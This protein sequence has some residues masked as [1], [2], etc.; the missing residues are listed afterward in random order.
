[1]ELRGA[2]GVAGGDGDGECLLDRL[3]LARDAASERDSAR[4][5]R[6]VR[7][8]ARLAGTPA[9]VNPARM[10]FL[11]S[12][13]PI[14]VRARLG[15][16]R[17]SKKI[18]MNSSRDSEK[19]KSSSPPPSPPL[20]PLPPAPPEPSGRGMRSPATYSR[21][22]GSTNSRSPP[23]PKPNDGSEMS[24]FGTRT[25][26]PCSMSAKR[27]SPTIF[28]TAVSICTLYRRRNRS[29]LT[30]LLPRPFGRRSMR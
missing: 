22:P 7:T 17:S 26:P 1:V 28:F 20:L 11:R 8:T 18:C 24:F 6:S 10:L 30:A 13:C 9:L 21:L 16:S 14:S 12:V 29:R 25:S 15:S 19:T 2:G 23:R 3:D 27:R 4:D 5:C